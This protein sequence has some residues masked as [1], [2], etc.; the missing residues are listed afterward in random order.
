MSWSSRRPP[1]WKAGTAFVQLVRRNMMAS[2]STRRA[3]VLSLCVAECCSP[4]W[5]R[6]EPPTPTWLTVPCDWYLTCIRLY[7]ASCCRDLLALFHR[8]AD[9]SQHRILFSCKLLD[10]PE[11]PVDDYIRVSFS[12]P[13]RRLVSR[14]PAPTDTASSNLAE[15]WCDSPVSR[16]QWSTGHL[17]VTDHKRPGFD[18]PRRTCIE[19]FSH[20]PWPLCYRSTQVDLAVLLT[21]VDIPLRNLPEF[22]TVQGSLAAKCFVH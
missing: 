1:L 14:S 10:R 19:P 8:S 11:L 9:V 17:W 5:T 2:A 6:R 21:V 13:P 22:S 7:S 16:L 12:H 20:Q 15:A 4:M 18:L 3:S